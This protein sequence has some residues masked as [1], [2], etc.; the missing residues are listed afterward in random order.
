MGRA[1]QKDGHFWRAKEIRGYDRMYMSETTAE[2]D[3]YTVFRVWAETHRNLRSQVYRPIPSIS[4]CRCRQRK[5][6][7]AVFRTTTPYMYVGSGNAN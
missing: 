4:P 6:A 2:F 5:E 3:V 7:P 1:C